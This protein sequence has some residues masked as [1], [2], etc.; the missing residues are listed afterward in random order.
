MIAYPKK[1]NRTWRSQ[2]EVVQAPPIAYLVVPILKSPLLKI[3]QNLR[4]GGVDDEDNR[5][6]MEIA[7]YK[8][9]ECLKVII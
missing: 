3:F 6:I 1:I 2:E 8:C 7:V 4:F 5:I 9:E